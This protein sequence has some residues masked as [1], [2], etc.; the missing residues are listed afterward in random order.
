[1]KTS[2]LIAGA[3]LFVASMPVIAAS[4]D[5]GDGHHMPMKDMTRADA[6][7][8]VKARFA[9]A[10]ANKDGVVTQEE[11]K[12]LREARMA[13]HRDA[14]FK[15]MDTNGDGSI[16]RAEFDAAAQ[17][18]HTRMTDGGK[19]GPR[20]GGH[21]RHHRGMEM[22]MGDRMFEKADANKDGKVTLAE[23]TG[24]AMA[25]FDA[26]DADRN[27]TISAQERINFWKTKKDEWKARKSATTS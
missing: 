24:A 10:D 3:A 26:V 25:H 6:E 21:G 5:G 1:M 15:L 22:G 7:A 17:G 12:A 4:Q 20:A 16:S 19:D 18:R 9:A 11:V 13:E 2:L 8:K 27:G 14:R 23:A